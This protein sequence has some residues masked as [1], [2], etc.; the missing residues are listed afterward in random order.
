MSEL[1]RLESIAHSVMYE[2]NCLTGEEIIMLYRR[3]TGQYWKY[4]RIRKGGEVVRVELLEEG[5]G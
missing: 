5:T 4:R 1:D 3:D 2:V